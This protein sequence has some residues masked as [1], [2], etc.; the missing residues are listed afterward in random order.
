VTK[1]LSGREDGYEKAEAWEAKKS[2]KSKRIE[3]VRENEKLGR[4]KS[5]REESEKKGFQVMVAGGA[6][7]ASE[8]KT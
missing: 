3:G 1:N 4:K 6:P 2:L 5:A 8:S 7:K